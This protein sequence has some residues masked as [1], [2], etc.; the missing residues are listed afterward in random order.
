MPVVP[1][2]RRI[3]EL[4]RLGI[5]EPML[6]FSSGEPLP[7]AF[8]WIDPILKIGLLGGNPAE[9]RPR[10]STFVQVGRDGEALRLYTGVAARRGLS[11]PAEP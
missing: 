9:G 5:S 4:R 8:C 2:E 3:A 7:F 6:R 11:T 1:E 10:C